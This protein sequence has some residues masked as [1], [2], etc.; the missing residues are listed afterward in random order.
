M[1]TPQ[2]GLPAPTTENAIELQMQFQIEVV[3]RLDL[4]ISSLRSIAVS[5]EAIAKK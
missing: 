2:F 1:S 4:L 5:I 3:K